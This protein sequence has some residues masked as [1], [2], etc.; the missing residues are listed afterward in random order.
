MKRE[1]V[2]K[3]YLLKVWSEYYKIFGIKNTTSN[4][5][6]KSRIEVMEFNLTYLEI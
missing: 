2:Q 1:V 6:E 3:Y 4:W 5:H